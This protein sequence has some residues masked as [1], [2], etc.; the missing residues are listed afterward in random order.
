MM[1]V[2]GFCRKRSWPNLIYYGGV[3]LEG[4]RK[5]TEILSQ[6]SQSPGKII[7]TARVSQKSGG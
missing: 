5:T 3:Y 1:S 2:K 7:E 6:H 4:L